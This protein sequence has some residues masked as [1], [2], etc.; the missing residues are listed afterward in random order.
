MPERRI[1]TFVLALGDAIALS[2][3]A[4]LGLLTHERG[5]TLDGVLRNAGPIL[6]GWFVVA[7]LVGLYRD[8]PNLGRLVLTWAVGVP[9]GIA[10]RALWLS[11]DFD[12]STMVFALVTLAVTIAFLG[13]WRLAA[14]LLTAGERKA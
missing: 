13:A 6:L 7:L 12:E 4:P 5:I 1:N 14:V 3:F 9:G 8:Y 10:I 11:R 2:L